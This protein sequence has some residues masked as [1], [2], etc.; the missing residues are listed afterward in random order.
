M[1]GR[2]RLA[3]APAHAA[4]AAELEDA[5]RVHSLD[6][7]FPRCVDSAAGGFFQGFARD[8]SP[9]SDGAKS[10]VFQA[11]MTWVAAAVARRG[12]ERASLWCERADHGLRFLR[13]EL[14]DPL[15]GG[16][17]WKEGDLVE[18][19]S[20]GIAFAIYAAAA[21]HRAGVAGALDLAKRALAWLDAGARDDEQGGY[22]EG[23]QRDGSPL[24]GRGAEGARDRMGVPV[25][26]KSANTHL[27]LLEAFAELYR[28]EPSSEHRSRLEELVHVL[29]EVAPGEDGSLVSWYTRDW[30]PARLTVCY[31]HSLEAA[32]LLLDAHALLGS[33]AGRARAI[34]D[35]ALADGYDPIYGGVHHEGAPRA[36]ASKHEK[37]WWVQAE[38]L[39]CLSALHER[40]GHETPRYGSHLLDTWRFIRARMLDP[41][42]CGWFG[43]VSRSGRR[44]LDAR[45]GHAWK[46]AYHDARALLEVP[47]RLRRLASADPGRS[48]GAPEE[49]G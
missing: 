34:A 35:R 43:V 20:Y 30:R 5:L 18:K 41:H 11:R 19:H 29:G 31:G 32:Y 13:D 2:R 48:S 15:C 25:G 38:A 33:D 3:T 36:A 26:L 16:F 9:A 49:R 45:K 7:W 27:H 8:W 10:L 40:Y 21:A 23:L 47:E 46:A 4:L 14:W 44:L 28:A 12:G 42:Q 37:V 6:C 39:N 1:A 22:F 17:L 24:V